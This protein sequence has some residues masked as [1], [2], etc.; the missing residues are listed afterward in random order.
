[1]ADKSPDVQEQDGTHKSEKQEVPVNLTKEQQK[2]LSTLIHGCKDAFFTYKEEQAKHREKPLLQP[3]VQD[4]WKRAVT[5]FD[6][7]TG[8]LTEEDIQADSDTLGLMSLNENLLQSNQAI[9]SLQA[10]A[11]NLKDRKQL[12]SFANSEFASVAELQGRMHDEMAAIEYQIYRTKRRVAMVLDAAQQK[13]QQALE[14]KIRNKNLT[15]SA[16]ALGTVAALAFSLVNPENGT[17]DLL[18]S[19]L[20]QGVREVALQAANHE[21]I[22]PKAASTIIELQRD[23]KP[24]LLRY[25]LEKA[26]A[27]TRPAQDVLRDYSPEL[28]KDTVLA[29]EGS[30]VWQEKQYVVGS[31]SSALPMFPEVH[32]FSLVSF[33]SSTTDAEFYIGADLL[34]GAEAIT[35]EEAFT[36][37][38][39]LH[40][41]ARFM[42]LPWGWTADGDYTPRHAIQENERFSG[43]GTIRDGKVIFPMVGMNEPDTVEI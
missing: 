29:E 12:H 37:Y 41:D 32:S 2:S 5:L 27:S 35:P 36:K 34:P 20:G 38:K 4:Q 17:I 1:M 7:Y 25:F 24:E 30:L 6:D 15:K 28:V 19:P 14:V 10:A 9:E 39:Q 8:L 33:D 21:L 3:P 18:N 11:N 23:P 31:A 26:V 16:V 22:S 13:Y 40:P 43:N 42:T